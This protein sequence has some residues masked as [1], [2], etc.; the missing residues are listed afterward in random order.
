MAVP[1]TVVEE[2]PL[3]AGLRLERTPE[4]SAL[5]IF[6]ASGDLAH[7]KLIPALYNL[8]RDGFLPQRYS[9]VG[10]CAHRDER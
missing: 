3:F 2:N 7:R 8:A 1:A 4:P 10:V 6:G 5:V 9:V